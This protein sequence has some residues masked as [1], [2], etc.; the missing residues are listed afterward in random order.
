MSLRYEITSW[1]QIGGCLSN[2]S[3]K[4]HAVCSKV[5]S[6]TFQGLVVRIDHD[7]YGCLFSYAVEGQG[8]LLSDFSIEPMSTKDILA[9]FKRF[10]FY[11]VYK[12]EEHLP[13]NMVEYLIT[14]DKLGYD[15]IRILFVDCPPPTAG[16]DGIVKYYVVA[17]KVKDHP[18]WINNTYQATEKEITE[19]TMAGTAINVSAISKEQN[20]RWNFLGDYVLNI[21]DIIEENSRR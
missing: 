13:G 2:T 8:S 21:S 20:F 17:F 5:T 10:G 7:D 6:D 16:E 9:Q 18:K 15:K 4:L 14:L 12:E 3:R 11:I 1:A 19:G